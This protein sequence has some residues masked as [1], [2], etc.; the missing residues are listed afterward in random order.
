MPASETLLNQA[1][2]KQPPHRPSLRWSHSSQTDGL[3]VRSRLAG[4]TEGRTDAIPRPDVGATV[5]GTGP[6]HGHN[7][8]AVGSAPVLYTHTGEWGW[9]D[10]AG[11]GRDSTVAS[12]TTTP[13]LL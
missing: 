6:R 7:S 3:R 13:C 9:M 11:G 4:W 8:A 5:R 12:G 10:G 1:A 2:W